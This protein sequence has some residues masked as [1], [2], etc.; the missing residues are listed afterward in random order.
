M[1]VETAAAVR[2]WLETLEIME[3][4]T[5]VEYHGFG[6]DVVLKVLFPLGELDFVMAGL[7]NWGVGTFPLTNGSDGPFGE[8]V[9]GE[10]LIIAF[11]A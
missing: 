4:V 11:L 2:G 5:P 9:D 10:E 7:S 6:G 8:V 3:G 1:N